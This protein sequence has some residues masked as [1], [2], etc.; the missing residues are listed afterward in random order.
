M[1][2]ARRMIWSD[3]FLPLFKGVRIFQLMPGREA[4]T[5]FVMRERFCGLML[6][7]VKRWLPDFGLVFERYARDLKHEA[8]RAG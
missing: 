6:P 8:E 1:V 3:G 7:L 2:P 5:T 4:S